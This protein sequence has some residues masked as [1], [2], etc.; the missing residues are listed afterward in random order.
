MSFDLDYLSYK[1]NRT[2]P[3]TSAILDQDNNV[4]LNNYVINKGNLK[5]NN[6]SGKIDLTIPGIFANY[7]YGAKLSFIDTD[8]DVNLL[9]YD[10]IS[11]V[12]ILSQTTQF[13]YQEN[14]Q[15]IYFS[16][17]KRIKKWEF[18]IGLRFE[19]TQ[20]KGTIIT[21]NQTNKTNYSK[22]FPTLFTTYTVNENNSFSFSLNRRINR[23]GYDYVNPAR[24]YNS[25]NNYVFGNPFLQ[26]SFVY[27]T[28][29]KH[30]YKDIFISS[31]S[32]TI[33]KNNISQINIPELNNIQV[34]TW[35]NYADYNRINLD[36]SINFDFNKRW[37]TVS[38]IY[39]YYVE[40][41]SHT[42]VIESAGSGMGG[43]FETRHTFTANK[44][45]TFFIEGFYWYDIK[46]RSFQIKKSPASSLD[47][48]FKH[49]YLDKKLQLTLVFTNILKSDRVTM[50]YISNNINQ[51]FR[52]Y[53]DSQSV[54]FALLYKLGNNKANVKQRKL[55][56]QEEL[57]RTN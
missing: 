27:N 13:N 2:N 38:S 1:N 19:N 52:Q 53:Y 7:E 20:T 48:S 9:F 22:F 24:R 4:I 26:P 50:S 5:I 8:S 55:G 41:K 31:A 33:G 47:I 6:Y 16:A 36:E 49:F 32:Y 3:F 56:N 18:K 54:R 25:I 21:D 43:G 46:S 44:A 34:A 42:P 39:Y 45:K 57:Q 23:P 11:N 29:L 15:S 10:N 17:N 37:S 28:E 35:E 40:Y 14:T 51:S 12:D 30:S